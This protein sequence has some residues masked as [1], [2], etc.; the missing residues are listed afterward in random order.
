MM[1]SKHTLIVGLFV[2]LMMAG[3]AMPNPTKAYTSID[4]YF[5]YPVGPRVAHSRASAQN[6]SAAAR[7]AEAYAGL[8][9]QQSSS[10]SRAVAS[11]AQTGDQ[12]DIIDAIARLVEALHGEETNTLAARRNARIVERLTL[13]AGAPLDQQYP[14]SRPPL[15]RTG[16]GTI[17]AM[18]A[19]FCAGIWTVRRASNR[20]ART[21]GSYR[22]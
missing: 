15:T 2:A 11:G 21:V 14:P 13:H 12:A 9:P 4:D 5:A 10:S 22:V 19:L 17:L 1:T 16:P 20:D 6:S 18:F 8:F 7:R 3:V